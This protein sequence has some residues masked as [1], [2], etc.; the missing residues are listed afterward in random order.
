MT[1]RY[2]KRAHNFIGCLYKDIRGKKLEAGRPQIYIIDKAESGPFGIRDIRNVTFTKDLGFIQFLF[3]DSSLLTIATGG[4]VSIE[5]F[6]TEDRKKIEDIIEETDFERI[7]PPKS[8]RRKESIVDVMKRVSR[9]F[10]EE[11]PQLEEPLT[12]K[13]KKR[14]LDIGLYDMED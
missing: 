9:Y 1:T 5:N 3:P 10:R 12:Y 7:T 6:T 4:G 14:R 2:N 8:K 11:M 13:E